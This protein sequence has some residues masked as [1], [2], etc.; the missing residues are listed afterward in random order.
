MNQTAHQPD[1]DI[2]SSGAAT[3]IDTRPPRLRVRSCGRTDVGRARSI[4]Q[5]H[6]LIAELAKTLC[7]RQTSLPQ[8]KLQHGDERGHLFVVADGMGGHAGGE[9]ASALAI[10]TVETFIINS[11]KWFFQLEGSE[12]KQVEEEF[13]SAVTQADERMF[14]ESAVHPELDGMGTTLTMAYSLNGDLFVVHVGDS[15]CYFLREGRLQRVTRDHTFVEEMLR[16]GMLAPDDALHHR[17]RHVITNAIGGRAPGVQVEVHKLRL[18]PGDVLLLCSD[19]LTDQLS[20]EQI[21]A[22]LQGA[23]DPDQCCQRLIDAANESGGKDNITAIVA[24]FEDEP[25]NNEMPER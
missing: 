10:E 11:V 18:Q 5:D 24:R 13:Q 21:A 17:L 15:R 25:V 9:Q 12:G 8:P 7:V 1:S 14:A 22:F 3:L 16:H 23:G 4:N 20:D 6:F 2:D 19:G